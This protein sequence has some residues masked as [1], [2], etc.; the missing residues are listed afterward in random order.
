MKIA[1]QIGTNNANDDFIKIVKRDKF[2]KVYLVEPLRR[3]KTQIEEAYREIPHELFSVA[4]SPRLDVNYAKLYDM[5]KNGSHDSLVKR[6]SHPI[7]EIVNDLAYSIVPCLTF[8]AL[9]GAIGIK[10]IELLCIDTEGLDDEII[11][12]IDFDKIKI[13]TIIWEMWIH[14]DDDE[15]GIFHT[16]P[17]VNE[18]AKAKLI[19]LG[20]KLTPYQDGAN[21][22]ATKEV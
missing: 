13:K 14:E 3:L 2:D 1:F 8:N 22:I 15:D 10:E 18:K 6:K 5:S 20:Y 4:I 9:C 7:R 11:L 19:A 21:M 16:G 17:S 12:S